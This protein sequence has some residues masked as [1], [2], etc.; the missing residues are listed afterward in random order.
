[1]EDEKSRAARFARVTA[2][3]SFIPLADAAQLVL[4]DDNE[5]LEAA[6][7]LLGKRP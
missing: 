1:L 4:P 2:A 5:V 3:D 7:Q 6:V